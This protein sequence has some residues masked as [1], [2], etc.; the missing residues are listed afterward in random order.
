VVLLQV[1]Q[2]VGAHRRSWKG[3]RRII[4]IINLNILI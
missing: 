4:D 3:I 2:Q 1:K